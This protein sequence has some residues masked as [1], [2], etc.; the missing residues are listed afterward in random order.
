MLRKR[1]ILGRNFCVEIFPYTQF[2]GTVKPKL[3]VIQAVVF[4]KRKKKKDNEIGAMDPKDLPLS[5][6]RHLM[7]VT[8]CEPIC[9][10]VNELEKPIVDQ[11]ERPLKDLMTPWWEENDG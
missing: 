11:L 9:G 5:V 7:E 4:K 3:G 2:I 1:Q 8:F 6:L 10:P